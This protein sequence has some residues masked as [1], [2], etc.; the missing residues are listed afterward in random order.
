MEIHQEL[1]MCAWNRAVKC[2]WLAGAGTGLVTTTVDLSV[3]MIWH[4]WWG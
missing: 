3:Y 1:L 4:D 2:C